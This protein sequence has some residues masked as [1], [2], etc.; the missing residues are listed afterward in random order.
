MSKTKARNPIINEETQEPLPWLADPFAFMSIHRRLAWLLRL[1]AMINVALA[2]VVVVLATT[3]SVL[4]PLKEIRT[5][6]LRVDPAEN[7]IYQ[8]E[9]ITKK[10]AGFDLLMEQMAKRYVRLIL[11]IDEVSQ[12]DRFREAFTYS[13]DSFYNKF[14]AE[15]ID[16][17]QVMDAIKSGLTR[18]IVVSSADKISE[19][20]DVSRY[21]VDFIQ[22]DSRKGQEVERKKIRAYLAMTTRPHEV[23]ESEK[24]D[25]P[26]GIRILDMSLKEK[27]DK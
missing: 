17:N 22:I 16:T 15:R 9:P 8:V 10:V 11:E 24:Y 19:R 6:L 4:M 27:E 3:I 1:S 14:K 20:D 2:C 5:A 21:A 26:L 7:R 18:S 25:N 12:T 23:R 13:D